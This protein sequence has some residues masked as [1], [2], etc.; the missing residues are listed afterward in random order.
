[1]LRVQLFPGFSTARLS[2]AGQP[3]VLDDMPSELPMMIDS[4]PVTSI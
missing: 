2:P 1:M 4:L 3:Y